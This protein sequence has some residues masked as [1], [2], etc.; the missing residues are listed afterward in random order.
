MT[1]EEFPPLVFHLF[2]PGPWVRGPGPN[3]QLYA[4]ACRVFVSSSAQT[5][6]VRPLGSYPSLPS[7]LCPLY[8]YVALSFRGRSP[9]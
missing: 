6:P 1:S 4:A 3:S 2:D 8:L 7:P 9:G 5:R